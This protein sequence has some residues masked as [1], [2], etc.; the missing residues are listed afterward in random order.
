[1]LRFPVLN[2]IKILLVVF[3]GILYWIAFIHY[4]ICCFILYHNNKIR[5]IMINQRINEAMAS[6]RQGSLGFDYWKNQLVLL[7]WD[8]Q[9]AMGIGL[10]YLFLIC[11]YMLVIIVIEVR[12]VQKNTI[13]MWCFYDAM[14]QYALFL[15]D[16]FVILLFK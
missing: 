11:Y 15:G 14:L 12:S 2:T 6:A 8:I 7:S 5:T 4:T 13:P 3:L 1:M 16:L 9:S 10:L